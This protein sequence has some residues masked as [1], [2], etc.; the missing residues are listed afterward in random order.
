MKKIRTNLKE[1]P[2]NQL[3]EFEPDN[4]PITKEARK[5]ILKLIRDSDEKLHSCSML[6]YETTIDWRPKTSKGSLVKRIKN[7]LY[8]GKLKIKLSD[9]VL[10]KIGTIIAEN[11]VA[12]KKYALDITED[13][14]WESGDFGDS[15]SCFWGGRNGIRTDMMKDGRFKALRFFRENGN[16]IFQDLIKYKFYKGFIGIGRSWIWT[17]TVTRNVSKDTV[18][19]SKVYVVFNGYGSN[20]QW[21]A[22]FL[23]AY[24][25]YPMKKISLHN[26]G[27]AVGGLY[28]NKSIGY[29]IG[30]ETVIRSINEL[31]LS[32]KINHCGSFNN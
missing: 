12:T 9:D 26:K 32:L 3:L 20:T 11:T 25:N 29:I 5:E 28:I 6:T 14:N 13:F 4:E 19:E 15:S 7:E 2:I 17:A 1:L 31:D 18:L 16:D 23:S 30:E 21:Q 8:R 10:Q 27:T 24:L 22:S